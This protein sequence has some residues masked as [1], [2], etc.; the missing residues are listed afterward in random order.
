MFSAI[1]KIIANN[2][3]RSSPPIEGMNRCS[4]R[5]T[6]SVNVVIIAVAGLYVPGDI[7]DRMIRIRI[8]NTNRRI[9]I[10]TRSISA[11]RAMGGIDAVTPLISKITRIVRY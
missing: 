4:G 9:V 3:D 11:V 2:G 8:A 1:S 6:G 5:N 7:H 10:M